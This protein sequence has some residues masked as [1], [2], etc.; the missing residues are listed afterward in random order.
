MENIVECLNKKFNNKY[1]YLKLLNVLY[2]RNARL[3]TITFLYP[4]TMDEVPIE[5]K[6]EVEKFIQEF[7]SLHADIKVKFR[8]SF[9]DDK[10]VVNEVEEFF[11]ENKK[12]LLPYL[13]KDNIMAS[14]NELNVEVKLTL[15]QD[16]LSLLDETEF[17][18]ELKEFL[19][20][21]F[22]ASFQIEIVE[23]GWVAGRD[24]AFYADVTVE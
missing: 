16:V 4:C 14:H 22:I 24:R 8:K 5:D 23:N 7:L 1:N 6:E 12:G 18:T 19:D 10:L 15:N 13:N 9:L 3:A 2:D 20:K 17:K 21:R 11:K